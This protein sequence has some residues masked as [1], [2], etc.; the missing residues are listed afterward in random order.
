MAAVGPFAKPLH[1]AVACSGGAD[2]LAL[3][4]LAD[5]WARRRGGTAVALTVDHGLRRESAA[6]ARRVGEWLQAR[7]IAHHVLR[8]R[9]AKPEANVAAAARAARYGLL[10]GWCRRRRVGDLLL[11]HQQEDQ[12]ETF[13]L[14]LARGSGVDGL[15]AM[16]PVVP[17]DGVRLLR[18]LLGVPRSRLRATLRRRRQEWIEDPSNDDPAYA[19]SRMRKLLPLLAEEG[20]SV[21]RLAGTAA[22]MAHVRTALEAATA[23]LVGAAAV[24]DSAGF[25]LLDIS[26]LRQAPLEIALRALSR[27]LMAFGG[28]PLPPRLERLERLLASIRADDIGAGRT[29]AGCRLLPSRGR[30]LICREAAAMAGPLALRSGRRAQ[31]DGRFAVLLRGAGRADGLSVGALGADGWRALAAGGS[32]SAVPGAVRPTLPAL[33]DLDG[34]V[35]VPH[36]HYRRSQNGVFLLA[37]FRPL[38]PLP[39]LNSTI[40]RSAPQIGSK[41]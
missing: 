25:A 12:A 1:V 40:V 21:A 11:A 3:T 26:P 4:L 19:R 31:W 10:L 17:A 27:L 34:I 24:V 32:R 15:A 28:T 13:L 35:A 23:D 16:A 8:W 39:P 5:A 41:V 7:G 18:P 30:L 37:E 9:G 38:R 29:L 2:S 22:R 33:R 36:L 6:E 20:L 14:R